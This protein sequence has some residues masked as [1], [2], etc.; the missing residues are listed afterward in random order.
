MERL[1]GQ[2]ERVCLKFTVQDTGKGIAPD[3]QQHI[4]DHFAQEDSSVTRKYGGTGLGLAICRKLSRLMGGDIEVESTLGQGS[5]FTFT[6]PFQPADSQELVAQGTDSAQAPKAAA[7]LCLLLVEDNQINRELAT[8]VLERDGHEVVGVENGLEALQILAEHDFDIVLMDVQMP[9]MDGLTASTIIR[10]SEK[11]S[12]LK[13]FDLPTELAE[14]LVRR[15]KN[16]HVPIVAM[17]AHAMSGDRERC[18]S[19]GM[20]EYMTKPFQPTQMAAIISRLGVKPA[21]PDTSIQKKLPTET[22]EPDVVNISGPESDLEAKV[23]KH[24]K[25]RY[26]LKDEQVEQMM[27]TS[28]KTIAQQINRMEKEADQ[29]DYAAL[30]DAA[31]GLKGSLLNLGLKDAAAI[32]KKIEFGAK[33]KEAAPYSEWLDELKKQI[34]SLCNL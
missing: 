9:M 16:G 19:A 15:C 1:D 7:S 2:K 34:G 30:A 10:A 33:G 26:Y 27:K 12:D 18:L 11:N 13:T 3:S 29:K 17:T 8:M 24:L 5:V 32:A 31:H 21:S 28:A 22:P 6:I 23:R 14:K 25:N 4:F 20:D